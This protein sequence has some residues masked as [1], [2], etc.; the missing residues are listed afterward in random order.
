LKTL[1][2]DVLDPAVKHVQH[3]KQQRERIYNDNVYFTASKHPENAPAWTYK[4]IHYETDDEIYGEELQNEEEYVRVQGETEYYGEGDEYYGEDNDEEYYSRMQEED[5]YIRMQDEY[6]SAR[7]QEEYEDYDLL[8]PGSDFIR[9]SAEMN[10]VRPEDLDE[11]GEGS[12]VSLVVFI[13]IF[14]Y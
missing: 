13:A 8:P 14:I 2:R 4:E 1:L 5:E 10:A 12:K 6:Y 11:Q 9:D 3:V 7:E